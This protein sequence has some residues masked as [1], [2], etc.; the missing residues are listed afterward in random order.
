MTKSDIPA[1]TSWNQSDL[2]WQGIATAIFI[3][4]SFKNVSNL[5]KFNERKSHFEINIIK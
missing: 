1:K 4:P 2:W 5:R 3:K